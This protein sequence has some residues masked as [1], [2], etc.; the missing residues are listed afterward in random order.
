MMLD[1][2]ARHRSPPKAAHSQ[3]ASSVVLVVISSSRICS[4]DPESMSAER[5]TVR[6]TRFCR[7]RAQRPVG[8]SSIDCHVC[9]FS[10]SRARLAWV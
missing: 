10:A 7:H 2:S 1:P 6:A 9:F 5:A 3:D 4:D 8:G